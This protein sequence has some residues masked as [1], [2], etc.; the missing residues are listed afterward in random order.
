MDC[1]S[2]PTGTSVVKSN[3]IFFRANPHL[4]LVNSFCT[5]LSYRLLA[6]VWARELPSKDVIGRSPI[7]INALE[8]NWILL[9]IHT[10]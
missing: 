6:T 5:I 10:S 2:V 4:Y 3:W 9:A 8:I 7:K 1:H